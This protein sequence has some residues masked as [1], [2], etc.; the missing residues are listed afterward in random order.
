VNSE[1]TLTVDISGDADTVDGL[2]ATDIARIYTNVSTQ[3]GTYTAS[4]GDL[5]LADTSGGGFTVT[6][7]AASS[8]TVVTVK[9]TDSSTNTVTVATPGAET[10]DGQTTIDIS[11]QYSS[12]D[13]VSDG[14]DYYMV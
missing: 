6:L 11:S 1:T 14:T 12:R 10:I 8:E 4:E 2:N 7:P 3:T 9:K 5:V 13:F